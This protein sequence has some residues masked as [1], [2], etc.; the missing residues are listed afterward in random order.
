MERLRP[1]RV[2]SPG[3]ILRREIEARDWTQKD[4]AAIIGRPPQAISEIVKGTKQITPETALEFS[5]AFGT[6]PE[7]WM[8][9]ETNYRLH[10]AEGRKDKEG[11]DRKGIVRKSEL[12]G[13]VPVAELIKRRWIKA[14][15]LIEELEREVLSFL[16]ISS[17]EE[18]PEIAMNFRHSKVREPEYFAKLAWIR[19][20]EQL[21][22]GQSVKGFD[23]RRLEQSL[24]A[25][26]DLSIDEDNV[27]K[28]SGILDDLGIHFVIVP[29]LPKTYIDGVMIPGAN[30]IVGLSLRHNRLDNFW[31][32]LAHELAHI[33]AGHDGMKVDEDG[34]EKESK[35]SDEVAANTM[36]RDWLLD[37]RGYRTFVAQQ[38]PYFSGESIKRFALSQSRHPSVVL[39][40][41]QHDGL[42]DYK[43][44]RKFH[45]KVQERLKV[46]ID[47][48]YVAR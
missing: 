9:L 46:L 10:L 40:R 28:V 44:L 24:P 8:N 32:T 3:T 37:G 34:F 14:A 45:V 36:A 6:S 33:V 25:L 35:N 13:Y 4:L 47:K 29:H 27:A 2:V 19:R 15:T 17:L 5:E 7:F 31:F 48:P 38:R 42:V 43:N 20:V 23:R 1:A 41:L 39:G 30:P 18:Q 21:A 22:M 26:I 12:Y 11:R 16:G